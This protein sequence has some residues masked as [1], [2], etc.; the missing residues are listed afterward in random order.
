MVNGS[1]SAKKYC[2]TVM[3]IDWKA[4][5][6]VLQ[7]YVLLCQYQYMIAFSQWRLVYHAEKAERLMRR[8]QLSA[9]FFADNEAFLLDLF[10]DSSSVS[11]YFDIDFCIVSDEEMK[12]LARP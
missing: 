10:Q 7:K 12:V 9:E 4:K 8:Y 3:A 11:A 6:A 1:K 2:Q 5:E